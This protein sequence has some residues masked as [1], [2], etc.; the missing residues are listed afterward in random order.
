M[1][2]SHLEYDLYV[3]FSFMGAYSVQGTVLASKHSKMNRTVHAIEEIMDYLLKN[4][5][6]SIIMRCYILL[7]WHHR[8]SKQLLRRYPCLFRP[9]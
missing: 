3:F 7:L 6:I 8:Q 2:L 1:V 4:S 9:L 5:V